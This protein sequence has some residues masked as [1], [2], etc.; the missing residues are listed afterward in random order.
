MKT[1]KNE[2]K[3]CSFKKNGEKT[4]RKR[5]KNGLGPCQKKREKNGFGPEKN[6][7]KTVFAILEKTVKKW[8]R[9]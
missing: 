7:K 9:L 3:N 8:Y 4:G 1:V 5:G 6:G 2:E